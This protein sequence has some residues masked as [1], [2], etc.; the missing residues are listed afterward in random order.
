M[1]ISILTV[2]F[3]SVHSFAWETLE[4]SEIPVG[5]SFLGSGSDLIWCGYL[6]DDDSLILA[7]EIDD[8]EDP[9]IVEA[10]EAVCYGIAYGNDNLWF[11]GSETLY[12]LSVNGN[13]VDN[14]NI[15]Y[16]DMRGLV[17][18]GDTFWTIANV[19][20]S[21]YLAQFNLNGENEE[22][23]Q[24]MVRQ[25]FDLAW[26]GDNFWIT[27]SSEGLVFR[28]SLE[29][30][31]VAEIL[32]S[33]AEDPRGICYY[34]E[35]IFLITEGE[36]DETD[37][38]HKIDPTQPSHARLLPSSRYH[39]IGA[40]VIGMALQWNLVLYNIGNEDLRIDSLYFRSRAHGF[41]PDRPY[42]DTV[43]QPGGFIVTRIS[44]TP[45]AYGAVMDTAWISSNDPE[46]PLV[47]V[48]V[49]GTGVNR[50][51]KLFI[52]PEYTDFGEVRADR[53]RD[54]TR[55]LVVNLI[56]QGAF[57]LRIDSINHRPTGI[58]QFEMP[59][60]PLTI[61]PADTLP[62]EIW[63][64]PHRGMNYYDTL[65]V[66]SNDPNVLVTKAFITGSGDDDEFTEGRVLWEY[67]FE[68]N[69]DGFGSATRN[70]DIDD[71][72]I[73][74]VIAVGPDGTVYCLNGFGSDQVDVLWKQSFEHAHIKPAGILPDGCMSAG[75]DINS[76]GFGDLI[77]G[78]GS[79]D[80][81]VY[82]ID[83]YNGDILW[84]WDSRAVEAEG[85]IV[86]V[87][88]DQDRNGD[89]AVD[90][91]VLIGTM[92]GEENTI[93]RLDGATGRHIWTRNIDNLVNLT[94]APD[95]THDGLN[96][97]A[98]STPDSSLI[99]IDGT[100][101][102]PII[103]INTEDY[104]IIADIIDVG[105]ID[106]DGRVDL[107]LAPVN[108][109]LIAY[110]LRTREHIWQMDFNNQQGAE[111]GR[112]SAL[113]FID[114]AILWGTLDGWAILIENLSEGEASW[115][116]QL[117]SA[118]FDFADLS[119]LTEDN[120]EE[121]VVGFKETGGMV[122]LDGSNGDEL[123]G[124]A[125]NL[126]VDTEIPHI[127]RFE[128]VDLGATDDVLIVCSDGIIRCLSSGGDLKVYSDAPVQLPENSRLLIS[129][130][131]FNSKTSLNF[132]L[133]KPAYTNIR[134][135]DMTGRT[136]LSRHLGML[137]AGDNRIAVDFLD[138]SALTSGMYIFEIK[139]DKLTQRKEAVYLK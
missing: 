63:F 73:D 4:S 95:L 82:G 76:D 78:S 48:T 121:Y 32:P 3:F 18:I 13:V 52:D 83:G 125:G 17:L 122:C 56:N 71:D 58:F 75:H 53:W 51:Q 24:L 23:Y 61:L 1:L 12:K 69:G 89:A 102:R 90:P 30:E 79:E 138:V 124:F 92:D 70:D 60:L 50:I 59:D 7:I 35:S 20:G 88:A 46:E 44:F 66:K 72:G 105:D 9:V 33:P 80:R 112:Y 114:H 111:Y 115:S 101:G 81:A 130:N 14:F 34:D 106:N 40:T 45:Q 41:Q 137:E 8:I 21:N 68:D 43:I 136:V 98:I 128:D 127:E 11:L 129:P 19:G 39:I 27:E 77:F 133:I 22:T 96:E 67:H 123:W 15:P 85:P 84:R 5:A 16:E 104:G 36:N 65:V 109:A 97:Y 47:G 25:P 49:V 113:A 120:I 6:L 117:R 42:Y 29:D 132:N 135:Y 28:Y 139:A 62:L 116:V 99:F 31:R 107:I 93:V 64:E 87:I 94:K 119:D 38:L 54:G 118:P 100:N 26:D 110:S 10:P 108:G 74:E 103:E 86:R 134:I 55:M 2:L 91:V 37:L 57:E 131:P 126:G